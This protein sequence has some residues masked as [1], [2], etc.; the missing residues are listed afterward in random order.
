MS[1]LD[2]TVSRSMSCRRIAT[3]SPRR[4]RSYISST[5]SRAICLRVISR[6]LDLGIIILIINKAL[7]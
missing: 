6:S 7:R 4:Q 2:S 5:S 1:A 3:V